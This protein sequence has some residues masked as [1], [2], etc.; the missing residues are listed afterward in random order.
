MIKHVKIFLSISFVVGFI[1]VGWNLFGKNENRIQETE[2]IIKV[3]C[4]GDSI[5][6]RHGFEDE[7]ENNYPF[8]LSALLGEKYEVV[9]FGESGTCVQIDGDCAY[10]DQEVYQ[11]GLEYEADVLIF[12][13]GTNDSKEWNW[14]DGETFRRAYETL[15][16]SYLGETCVPTVYIG[17]SPK[18]FYVK[19]ETSGAAGFGI[20]PEI[21]EQ[22]VAIQREVAKERGYEMIDIYALSDKYPEYFAE[23]G[24]HPTK[25][26]AE[27][28]AKVVVEAILNEK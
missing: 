10:V 5:T 19:G 11:S 15:L 14:K 3:A 24:I 2:D 26:G 18:A 4:V 22:I 12:M 6:F 8:V 17:I 28:I 13:I 9:N 21:V 25:E 27:I 7:P 20:Q 23:D 1:F 16:D